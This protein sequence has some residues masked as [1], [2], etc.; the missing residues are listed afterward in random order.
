VALSERLA[1]IIDANGAGA[2]REFNKV[3]K[4]ADKELGKSTDRT[5]QLGASLTQVGAVMVGVGAVLVGGAIKAAQAFE[6]QQMAELRLQ[7]T[8]ERMPRL[9]G[10]SSQAFLDQAS[11]L[12]RVTKYGD[13]TT[14]AS[15]AMLGTFNM[16]EKQIL[17]LMPLVQDYASKFGT[18][19]VD[20]SKQ[21]GKAV[22]GQ[23]GAL[24]RNGVTIDEN[25]Y[26]TD[27]F[28]A[29]MQALRDQAGGF[30]EEEGKTMSGQLAILKNNLGDVAETVGAGAVGAFNK[31]LTPLLSVSDAFK[32][33][34]PVV[35]QAIGGIAA[36]GGVGLIFAGTT[37]I[38]IGQLLLMKER[39]ALAYGAARRFATF[40]RAQMAANLLRSAAMLGVV[41]LAAA[42]LVLAFKAV[43]DIAEK[44]VSEGLRGLGSDAKRTETALRELGRTGRFIGVLA[45]DADSV[46]FAMQNLRDV[47]ID[48]EQ[49]GG[50]LN[51]LAG[52]LQSVTGEGKASK[53]ALE[54][55]DSQLVALYQSSV[56]EANR[57]FQELV[58]KLKE[59]GWTMAD[60]EA[61]FPGFIDAQRAGKESTGEFAEE[62]RILVEA[63]DE[64][65][66]ALNAMFDPVFGAIKATDGLRDAQLKAQEAALKVL[67]AQKA[68]DE[69]LQ[70]YEENSPEVVQ[71]ALNLM[72]AH[73]DLRE[74]ELNTVEAA[75][76]H[77]SA[78]LT[79]AR[80]QAETGGSTKEFEKKLDE[81]VAKGA[82]TEGQARRM[83]D[84]FYRVRDAAGEIPPSTPANIESNASDVLQ[85]IQTMK[86]ELEGVSRTSL[87]TGA[88]RLV[89]GPFI[90]DRF[91]GGPV[92]ARS[93]YLVGE[94]GPELFVPNG[95]GTVMPDH[96]TR[97]ALATMERPTPTAT[98]D[99]YN[100]TINGMVGRD[101]REVLEFLARELPKAAVRAG[102]SLG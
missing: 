28:A 97:T 33:M 49:W 101:K 25:L 3:G 85:T 86:R 62:T 40:I 96:R 5:R 17:E 87:D 32:S 47:K 45:D 83:K 11:A 94:R 27:R 8:I 23:R 80:Q 82:I 57:A 15:Q 92:T 58:E 35:G 99:T 55:L 66:D 64:Q 95:S 29:V 78:L 4:S 34:P 10:A 43:G 12:Q 102:R 54:Q 24:Q 76:K 46:R 53:E 71:A 79:L 74:A 19:L 14:I 70:N 90:G 88:K 77:E 56:S 51:A 100:I 69:A 48:R 16:T 42:G 72:G 89:F 22:M 39:F 2:V 52:W 75:Q 98:G 31:L 7:N 13:E 73:K 59:S 93:P 36:F 84:E 38:M 9:A 18:D 50:P 41:G 91:T 61:A 1:I 20:A 44:R 37:S 30:A 26:K 63:L 68:Y 21:V 81:W 60:I 65:R 67:A 6:R